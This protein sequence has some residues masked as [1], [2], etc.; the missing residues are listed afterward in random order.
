M[1]LVAESAVMIFELPYHILICALLFIVIVLIYI[2]DFI[3]IVN[4]FL[5]KSGLNRSNERN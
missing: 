4:V 2:K 5:K 3:E 1:I